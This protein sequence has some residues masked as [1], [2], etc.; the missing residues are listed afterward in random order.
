[1]RSQIEVAPA[2]PTWHAHRWAM[3]NV[4]KASPTEEFHYGEPCGP[5]LP[6]PMGKLHSRSTPKD[7]SG[8]LYR[9]LTQEGYFVFKR[10]APRPLSRGSWRKLQFALCQPSSWRLHEGSPSVMISSGRLASNDTEV[11]YAG[12]E[13]GFNKFTAA[14]IE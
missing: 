12:Y 7:G 13:E 6:R 14:A 10:R 8:L 11:L 4:A 3:A 1:M 2:R 9:T 5:I